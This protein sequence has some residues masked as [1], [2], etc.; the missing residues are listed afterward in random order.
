MGDGRLSE[1]RRPRGGRVG[2]HLD[3]ADRI[4]QFMISAPYHQVVLS[5]E[6]EPMLAL[7]LLLSLSLSAF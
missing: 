7:L 6:N 5:F 4:M 2:S 3:V 1:V